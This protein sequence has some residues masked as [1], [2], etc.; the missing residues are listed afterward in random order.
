MKNKSVLQ[1]KCDMCATYSRWCANLW[2]TVNTYVL[3]GLQFGVL[4]NWARCSNK[5]RIIQP[6]TN[7]AEK[8]S[9]RMDA[10]RRRRRQKHGDVVIFVFAYFSCIVQYVQNIYSFVT[11]RR[12][13]TNQ[14]IFTYSFVCTQLKFLACANIAQHWQWNDITYS[15]YSNCKIITPS[16]YLLN[17]LCVSFV[18]KVFG[19]RTMIE[20]CDDSCFWLKSAMKAPWRPWTGPTILVEFENAKKTHRQSITN[21]YNYTNH[22][23]ITPLTCFKNHVCI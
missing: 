5:F 7:R 23:F 8:L 18:R 1:H 19:L 20:R 16:A 12:E 17:T 2:H 13:I 15:M 4:M 10:T 3:R 11:Q 9:M 14:P 22:E 21:I 6:K